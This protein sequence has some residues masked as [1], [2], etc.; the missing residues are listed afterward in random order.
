M[1]LVKLNVKLN[2]SG[3]V[4]SN[5]NALEGYH[6]KVGIVILQEVMLFVS[7]NYLLFTVINLTCVL[8]TKIETIYNRYPL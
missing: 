3:S 6:L 4:L 1:V 2:L 7:S 8:S 5:K